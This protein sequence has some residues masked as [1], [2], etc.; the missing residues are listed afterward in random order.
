M[1]SEVD[2]ANRADG[3]G[4]RGGPSNLGEERRPHVSH[5]G[6]DQDKDLSGWTTAWATTGPRW[7]AAGNMV[8]ETVTVP[9]S[10][11]HQLEASASTP[12]QEDTLSAS[13]A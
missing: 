7:G 11:H 13:A 12:L 4:R 8:S 10:A 5:N 1:V 2:G 9:S 3:A 6:Q